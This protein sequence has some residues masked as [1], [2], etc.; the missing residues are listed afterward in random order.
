MQEHLFTE[1]KLINLFNVFALLAQARERMYPLHMEHSFR[2]DS[3]EMSL[4]LGKRLLLI[5]EQ[6]PLSAYFGSDLV[7]Q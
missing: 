4:P 1:M 5:K 3:K 6:Y 2:M 7:L